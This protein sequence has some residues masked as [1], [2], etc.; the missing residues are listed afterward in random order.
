[1]SD[2]VQILIGEGSLRA[3]IKELK[4]ALAP[5]VPYTH[6]QLQFC[7]AA[8]DVK[9]GHIQAALDLL[10]ENWQMWQMEL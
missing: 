7:Q 10:A 9:D 4:N 8:H 1:M 5:K 2:D 3:I 6:D